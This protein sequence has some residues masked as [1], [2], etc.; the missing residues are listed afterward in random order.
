[1]P[2]PAWED[3]DAFLQDDDFATPAVITLQ[4]GGTIALSV[5][6]DDPARNADAGEYTHDTTGPKAT[7]REDLVAA[8]KRGD[9]IAIALRLGTRTFDI[10]RAPDGDGTGMATLILAA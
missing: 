1:M 9:S 10:L 3:L 4:A 5:I 6:F 7:C 8:V 2:A